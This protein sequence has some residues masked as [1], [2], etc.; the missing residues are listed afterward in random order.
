[1]SRSKVRGNGQGTAYRR[2]RTW[3]A[4]VV[5]GYRLP[6]D[7]GKQPIP[8]K[9]RKCGFPTK[10]AAIAACVALRAVADKPRRLTMDQLYTEWERSYSSRVG[11]STMTCYDSAYKHFAALHHTYIDLI[12]ARDLQDCMDACQLG[13]RTHQNMKCIARLLWAYALDAEYV[14]RDVT[15]NLYIGKGETK[16]REPITEAELETIRAAIP[17]EPY[18]AYV[19]CLCYLGF[20]PGEFLRLRKTDLQQIGDVWILTGGSKTDAG[21]DRRVPVP[22]QILGIIQER[23]A[24]PDTELLFPR[25]DG[26]LKGNEI[27]DNY[28][29]K[30]IFQPL[31]ARLGITGKVPYSARHTYSDKL[32]S[33]AGDDKAKAAI[34]GHT[35]YAFTRAKYQS[36]DIEDLKTIAESLV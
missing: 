15:A 11:A 7:P 32:K 35:D 10:A 20:R 1:M 31:M 27:S 17:A 6:D 28:F 9:R 14:P 4:Q 21:R 33:A 26:R 16:Q 19:Y 24:A 18:A 36:T 3:E 29:N 22:A 12:T 23:M 30:F 5:I 34:M 8:I 2:G 25:L 13:K